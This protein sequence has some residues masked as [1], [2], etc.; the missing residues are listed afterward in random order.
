MEY[1]LCL[2]GTHTGVSQR[3]TKLNQHQVTNISAILYIRP[4]TTETYIRAEAS[5]TDHRGCSISRQLPVVERCLARKLNAGRIVGILI[6]QRFE[7]MKI[8]MLWK[9]GW[10]CGND[11]CSSPANHYQPQSRQELEE[12][13][14]NTRWAAVRDTS[15]G[16]EILRWK[17]LNTGVSGGDEKNR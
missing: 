8:K 5:L 2:V 10:K 13:V 12:Q 3:N 4:V 17:A 14:C 16:R 11:A 7:N 15:A 6:H 9:S 1:H